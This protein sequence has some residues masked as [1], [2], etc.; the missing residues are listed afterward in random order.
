MPAIVVII[1]A[2][3]VVIRLIFGAE[4]IKDLIIKVL[5]ILGFSII[6]LIG[7]NAVISHYVNEIATNL[8][9]TG[10]LLLML[11]NATDILCLP[12]AIGGAYTLRWTIKGLSKIGS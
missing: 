7:I 5:S 1:D 4:V 11:L 3:M 8:G 2:I 6:S 9:G 12:A 10:G